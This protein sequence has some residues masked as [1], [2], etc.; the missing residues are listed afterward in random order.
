MIYSSGIP[1]NRGCGGPVHSDVISIGP[2]CTSSVEDCDDGKLRRGDEPGRIAMQSERAGDGARGVLADMQG[3]R[4]T[5]GDVKLYGSDD[6][7]E[8]CE[9]LMHPTAR[10][11]GARSPKQRRIWDPGK[12]SLARPRMGKSL[13]LRA[14]AGVAV[15]GPG[16]NPRLT[17]CPIAKCGPEFPDSA[18]WMQMN[19][20]A[21]RESS[22]G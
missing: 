7:P 13:A 6:C 16:G 21:L 5:P 20:A 22:G 10:N 4:Q 19:V 14:T 1:L 8:I 15:P 12:P 2:E 9:G 17:N 18:V 3:V 11:H